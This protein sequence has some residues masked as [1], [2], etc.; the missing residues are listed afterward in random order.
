MGSIEYYA[1]LD[2][3]P[4]V[5]TLPEDIDEILADTLFNYFEAVTKSRSL[6]E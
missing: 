2:T 1:N 6:D 5:I 3:Q 4:F